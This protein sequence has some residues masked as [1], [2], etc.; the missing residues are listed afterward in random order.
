MKF[1]A[2]IILVFFYSI[3]FSQ[4]DYKSDIEKMNKIGFEFYSQLRNN[5][6][7]SCISPFFLSNS[8]NM[9]YLSTKGGTKR[10]FKE[11]FEFEEDF[12]S[13]FEKQIA[14]QEIVKK[15]NSF[16]NNFYVA[17]AI[18]LQDSLSVNNIFLQ[19]CS[20]F[21]GDSVQFINFDESEQEIIMRLNFWNLAQTNDKSVTGLV[22]T[23][24]NEELCMLLINS[25]AFKGTWA[26][27]FSDYKK[28][29][30]YLDNYE[31][32]TRKIDYYSQKNY[33][34][35]AETEKYQIIEIPYNGNEISM[36]VIMPKDN[37]K[38]S[39]FEN[40]FTSVNFDFWQENMVLQQVH[41]LLPVFEIS[42]SYK[43]KDQLFN[44]GVQA[45]FVK[46]ANFTNMISKAIYLDN[47]IHSASVSTEIS[48]GLATI[49]TE[50]VEVNETDH[51]NFYADH[52]FIFVI[53]DNITGLIYFIGHIIN[54][55]I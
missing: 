45:A 27:S 18:W 43:I 5:N 4:N 33:F 29:V 14:I 36:I 47:V 39:E 19:S 11:V 21:W 42:N 9:L 53:K 3:I 22:E 51:I 30:F 34:R 12:A 8:I 37:E 1:Y 7:N 24:I 26:N 16:E 52:P 46:G 6:E 54:P 31:H 13:Q 44:M 2:T 23:D 49:E 25:V 48:E 10:Q 35:F 41:L 50:F 38:I 40:D 55:S 17:N 15:R 28:D 20:K 32:K